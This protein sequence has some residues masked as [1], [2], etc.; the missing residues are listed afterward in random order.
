MSRRVARPYAAALFQVMERQ[1]L[2]VL[3]EVEGQLG[4]VAEVF[5]REPE[6]VRV[7][8]VPSVTVAAKRA[9]LEAIG[10]ACGLRVETR[11]MLAALAQH[12]RLRYLAEVAAAFRELVDRKEGVVRGRLE[13]A[14]EPVPAQ[15]AAV[16]DA[17]QRVFAAR[18]EL[19][20]ERREELLAGFVVR[21]GSRVLD[22][23]LRS[24]VER[25]AAAAAKE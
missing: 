16:S 5:A 4:T 13:L 8:E 12:V 17:L 19:E 20:A 22:G 23:S 3:R 11:R 1:G 25:F 7:F 18:V 2:A 10:T 6:L 14:V 9:L 15:V 24:Q 21:V